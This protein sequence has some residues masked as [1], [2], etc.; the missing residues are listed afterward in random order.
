MG[1][2]QCADSRERLLAS[3]PAN[4]SH[5]LNEKANANIQDNLG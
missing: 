4:I 1:M 5:I 3:E 2:K